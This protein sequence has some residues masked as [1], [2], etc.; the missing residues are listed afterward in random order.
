MSLKRYIVISLLAVVIPSLIVFVVMKKFFKPTEGAKI[1]AYAN[2]QEALLVIDVQEDYPGLRG[3]QPS[4]YKNVEPQIA[5]IN[6]LIDKA[7]K[8]GARVIYIRQIF[9]DDF[10]TRLLGGRAIESKP[11]TEV[12]S[13]I[14]VASR[15]D[16]TKKFSDA[17]SNPQLDEFLIRNQVNEL[18]LVGL[19]A[20]T[21][22]TSFRKISLAFELQSK[23]AVD[24]DV[25]KA[26]KLAKDSV[27][28][29]WTMVK[30][31]VE[32]V[33]EYKMMKS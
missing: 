9:D 15:N 25:Q 14:N 22:P 32:I 33:T 5:V 8:S 28:A 16:L 26:L 17:F 24:A 30:G 20:D 23:D 1:A 13:R 7:S 19:D 2:P 4:L 11:G 18:Y 12:H 29:V 31:N 3:K 21:S 6:T 10:I 27:C